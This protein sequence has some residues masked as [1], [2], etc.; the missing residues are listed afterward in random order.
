MYTIQLIFSTTHSTH[1]VTHPATW[2]YGYST[3]NQFYQFTNITSLCSSSKFQ[4]IN[5]KFWTGAIS[6]PLPLLTIY[7][8]TTHCW[9]S[10]QGFPINAPQ[11]ITRQAGV[12][13]YNKCN[14][15]RSNLLV[16]TMEQANLT[17]PTLEILLRWCIALTYYVT[18]LTCTHTEM[19]WLP[20][21]CRWLRL[22]VHEQATWLIVGEEKRILRAQKA[23]LHWLVQLIDTWLADGWCI[24][25]RTG[26]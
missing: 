16:N 3:F 14:D 11:I 26:P 15:L 6:D 12:H 10:F 1:H 25:T 21:I 8:W 23:A 20:D 22:H 24:D 9:H 4:F 17:T 18:L 2:L 13:V 5:L 19:K 7:C